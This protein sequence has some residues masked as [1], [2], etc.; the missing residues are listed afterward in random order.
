VFV[1]SWNKVWWTR[2]PCPSHHITW[3]SV[4]ALKKF[5]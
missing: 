4:I 2:R 3:N 5:A 1:Q